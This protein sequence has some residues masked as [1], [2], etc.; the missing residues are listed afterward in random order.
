MT[1][2]IPKLTPRYHL[3]KLNTGMKFSSTKDL[4]EEMHRYPVSHDL[5]LESCFLIQLQLI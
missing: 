4:T 1:Y 5:T 3:Q 2:K